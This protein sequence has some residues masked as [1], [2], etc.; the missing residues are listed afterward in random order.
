MNLFSIRESFGEAEISLKNLLGLDI[1]QSRFE[2]VNR[3]SVDNYDEFY[4]NKELPT[5]E[6]EGEIQVISFDGKGVPVI[7]KEAAKIQA[8]LGKGEKR[9]KKKE[10]MVGVDYTIDRKIRSLEEVAENLVYPEQAGKKKRKKK[11]LKHQQ[12]EPGMFVG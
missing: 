10:A 8:R 1:K 9:Q 7:K 12:F 11:A 2:V 5:T 6:S 4:K 3:E